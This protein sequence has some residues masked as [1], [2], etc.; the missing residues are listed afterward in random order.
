MT[1]AAIGVCGRTRAQVKLVGSIASKRVPA[2]ST[3]VFDERVFDERVF[4]ER[5]D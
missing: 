4:D 3:G 1:N 2:S 5:C